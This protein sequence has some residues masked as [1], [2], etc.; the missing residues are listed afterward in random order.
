MHGMCCFEFSFVELSSSG[1]YYCTN[2]GDK[3]TRQM[4]RSVAQ[5]RQNGCLALSRSALALKIALWPELGPESCSVWP[6][7]FLRVLLHK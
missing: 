4:S 3:E 7:F 2:V 5:T 1:I 6:K